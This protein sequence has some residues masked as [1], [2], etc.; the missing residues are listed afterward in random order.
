MEITQFSMEITQ[1]SMEI[2]QFLMEI[3]QFSS[4]GKKRVD[5]DPTSR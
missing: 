4:C 3:T 1:F 5:Q 2:T